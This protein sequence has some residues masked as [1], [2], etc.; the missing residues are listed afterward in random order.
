M[1]GRSWR[2][3]VVV[4]SVVTVASCGQLFGRERP[5]DYWSTHTV[6]ELCRYPQDFFINQLRHPGLQV[7]D[8]T[9]EPEQKIDGYGSCIMNGPKGSLSSRYV[10][11]TLGQT[12]DDPIEGLTADYKERDAV[13]VGADTVR[14]WS[15]DDGMGRELRVD[16]DGWTGHLVVMLHEIG[17][18]KGGTALA[19][20]H[21]PAAAEMLVRMTHDLKGQ[22]R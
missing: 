9:S 14:V 16:I 15:R 22:P 2:I 5:Q 21:L 3:A 4:F 13:H 11:A 6:G 12:D 18:P 1:I 7:I 10:G 8:P 17:E 19:D 20:E